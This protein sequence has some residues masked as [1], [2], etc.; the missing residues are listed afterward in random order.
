[1]MTDMP[2]RTIPPPIHD[3]VEFDF[4]L[5]AIRRERL[6][7]GL[8]LYWLNA[9]VQDVVEVDFIFPAGIWYE[10]KPAVAHAVA[11]LLKNGTS[12][13][14][15][16][17]LHEALE[18]YGASLKVQAGNDFATLTLHTLT[19]HLPQLLP[20]VH[21]I[22]TDAVFPEEELIIYRQN[23]LQ[24]LLVSLRQCEFVANQRIDALLFGA[25][26]PYGRFTEKET[27]EA[28][29]REDLLAFYR[30]HYTLSRMQLFM[31]GNVGEK[32]VQCLDEIFGKTALPAATA[33]EPSFTPQPADE[34]TERILNDP[35]GVQGAIRIGRLFPGRRHPDF[36][37]M[38]V[39]NTLFGG[40]FG[41][42]LMSNIREEKGY[43]YGIYSSLAPY[44]HGGSIIVHT[45]AGRDVTEDAVKEIYRE[46]DILRRE[47]VPEEELLLVKNYLLGNLL[48]DLDGPF[49]ILQ[50]WRTLILNG[51]TEADFNNNVNVYK[52]ITAK[53]LLQL[54]EKY[55]DRDQFYEVVVI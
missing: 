30:S 50:R 14:S 31:A 49:S 7:N 48:G 46:M 33:A 29:Q 16:H 40:Y 5:P 21:E 32:E 4:V 20:V 37:P 3:A 42:R 13:R 39:L 8:P 1:M 45:E 53:E 17:A 35:N 52:T 47:A 24:R 55:F 19:R 26:H 12:K 54:A 22:I 41:S 2:D 51:F 27:I 10:Q 34:R 28:L 6:G 38:V 18:F 36:A 15:A 43:T 23:A 25:A 11:G 9:G 44:L